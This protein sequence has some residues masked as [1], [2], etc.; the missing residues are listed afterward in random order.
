MSG[1][2]IDEQIARPRPHNRSDNEKNSFCARA[3]FLSRH[4]FD[5]AIAARCELCI[6]IIFITSDVGA[7]NIQKCFIAVTHTILRDPSR[8][9]WHFNGRR[10]LD[11][12]LRTCLAF[13]VT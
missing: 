1:K 5:F 8:C 2:E 10:Y 7:T 6:K 12:S 11:L 3:R 13:V 4:E 9:H